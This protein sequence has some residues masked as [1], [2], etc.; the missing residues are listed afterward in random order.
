MKVVGK[1]EN[2]EV[3]E[4]RLTTVDQEVCILNY[5]CVVRSW[6]IQTG[7]GMREIVLGFDNFKDYPD[8]SPS[9][10]IIAGRVANRTHLGQFS[11]DGVNHQLDINNGRHHLHGGSSG[12][13]KR[14]WD[15]EHSS[16]QSVQLLFVSRAGDQGYPA[17]VVFKVTYTLDADGL[18][19][20][21]EAHPSALTPINLAQHNYYNLGSGDDIL[22]HSLWIDAERYLP[23]DSE[24]IPTGETPSVS[25][26]RFDFR[27]SVSLG[28]ADPDL[29]GIDHNLILNTG[30]DNSCPAATLLSPD[31][32]VSLNIITDQPGIQ[33]YT[34]AKLNVQVAGL[35]GKT[36]GA[37]AGLCLEP[38]H[39]PDSLN[40]PDFPS[41]LYSPDAPYRQQ[42]TMQVSCH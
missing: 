18:H 17:D 19:C 32:L 39:F 34:G 40:R 4:V 1:F 42:L 8:H 14:V 28:A 41:I 11:L 33:L 26:S 24:L 31:S 5:G 12:L 15:I 7:H 30:R 10:G 36:Y 38:Q 25:Q 16:D 35:E 3:I 2:K 13:G 27:S 6:K 9:F 21:M 37:F 23:V 29:Q 20:D 22:Q